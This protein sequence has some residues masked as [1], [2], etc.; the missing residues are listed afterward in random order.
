M[1]PVVLCHKYARVRARMA[2]LAQLQQEVRELR[3][4]LAAAGQA[5]PPLGSNL[6]PRISGSGAASG[7]EGL[8]PAPAP[9]Q[10]WSLAGLSSGLSATVTE[11]YQ[12]LATPPSGGQETSGDV[13]TAAAPVPPAAAPAPRPLEVT[14][15]RFGELLVEGRR[16]MCLCLADKRGCQVWDV[17][18]PASTQCQLLALRIAGVNCMAPLMD[19]V[20]G[21]GA[22]TDD[23]QALLAGTARG[24]GTMEG[25]GVDVSTLVI[26]TTVDDRNELLFYSLAA[27]TFVQVARPRAAAVQRATDEIFAGGD[28]GAGAAVGVQ[29]SPP[30]IV[31]AMAADNGMHD[32]PLAQPQVQL[33]VSLPRRVCSLAA[34][35]R[36]VVASFEGGSV[37]YDARSMLPACPL[38]CVAVLAPARAGAPPRAAVAVSASRGWLAYAEAK[39]EARAGADAGADAEAEESAGAGAGNAVAAQP[40]RVEGVGVGSSLAGLEQG[41]ASVSGAMAGARQLLHQGIATVTAASP[42]PRISAGVGEKGGVVVVEQLCPAGLTGVASPRRFVAHSS[43]ISTLHFDDSG[44]LLVTASTNGKTLKVFSL[45]DENGEQEVPLPLAGE[46]T[47]DGGGDDVSGGGGATHQWQPKLLYRLVRGALT[48]ADICSVSFSANRRWL[49]VSSSHGTVHIFAINA[50]GGHVDA[51]THCGGGGGS[52]RPR[53]SGDGDTATIVPEQRA[54]ALVKRSWLPSQVRPTETAP[55]PLPRPSSLD[56]GPATVVALL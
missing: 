1:E 23:E 33:V 31:P 45:P 21:D 47:I 4:A 43:A 34:A 39:A 41:L 35:A 25:L 37:V 52:P 46:T 7:N 11:A 16:R 17:E 10:G 20:G 15:C 38:R 12:A 50:H 42:L 24:G 51:V 5:A 22:Q 49:A 14:W 44:M 28:V 32:V 2:Q 36:H 13:G 8:T 56:T 27:A 3:A 29:H 19:S 26:S 30:V 55:P 54:V 53:R 40:A 6:A 9:A 48:H 18:D